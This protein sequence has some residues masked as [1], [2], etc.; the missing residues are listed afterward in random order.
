[1]TRKLAGP[2]SARAFQHAAA[3]R[4]E[5]PFAGSTVAF[6]SQYLR[7][8]RPPAARPAARRQEHT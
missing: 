7:I 4:I 6:P 2:D 5:T 1:M 3:Y 8:I